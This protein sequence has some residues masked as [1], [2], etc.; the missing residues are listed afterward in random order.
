[1]LHLVRDPFARAVGNDFRVVVH[2]RELAL[3][4]GGLDPPPTA[5]RI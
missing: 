1:M 2:N 5:W 3:V 4:D